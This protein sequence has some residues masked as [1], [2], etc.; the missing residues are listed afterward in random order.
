MQRWK[1][2]SRRGEST[3][4][5]MKTFVVDTDGHPDV[6]TGQRWTKLQWLNS[7]VNMMTL[8]RGQQT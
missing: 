6:A 4:V 5:S 1:K 8:D 7:N 2:F 3:A